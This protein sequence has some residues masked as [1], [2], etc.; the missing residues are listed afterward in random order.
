MYV[1][2]EHRSVRPI[3]FILDLNHFCKN[4]PFL[5]A[6]VKTRISVVLN[7]GLPVPPCVLKGEA[8]KLMQ[9]RFCGESS[10]SAC[11]ICIKKISSV[12]CRSQTAYVASVPWNELKWPLCAEVQMLF[13]INA[14]PKAFTWSCCLPVRQLNMSFHL[15][16]FAA[17]VLWGKR[18]WVTNYMNPTSKL[19]ISYPSVQLESEHRHG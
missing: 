7:V 14:A 19:V 18:L 4:I 16:C 13:S 11:P 5:Q 15:F 2:T 10:G 9:S 1:F 6:G 12:I 17:R 3:Q 8:D